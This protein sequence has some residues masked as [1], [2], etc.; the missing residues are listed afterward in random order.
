MDAHFLSV[1]LCVC[2]WTPP[3]WGDGSRWNFQGMKRPLLMVHISEIIPIRE[4]VKTL[5]ML[6]W[7]KWAKTRNKDKKTGIF[8]RKQKLANFIIQT[9]W[10]NEVGYGEQIHFF[11]ISKKSK[12]SYF[13]PFCQN[14]ELQ[15]RL[16]G[17]DTF[18]AQLK[19]VKGVLV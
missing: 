12:D 10:V 7:K 5:C 15:N 16:W 3:R 4:C 14:H 8:R 17:E 13:R 19:K 6:L 9:S 11:H 2:H 1:C 18:F